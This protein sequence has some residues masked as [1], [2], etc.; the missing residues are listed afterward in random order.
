MRL[1]C[2]LLEVPTQAPSDAATPIPE[3]VIEASLQKTEGPF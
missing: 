2:F 1:D 3:T